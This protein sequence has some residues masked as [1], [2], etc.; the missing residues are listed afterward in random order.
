MSTINLMFGITEDLDKALEEIAKEQMVE[1][2]D[3]ARG[4]LAV[5]LA[6]AKHRPGFLGFDQGTVVNLVTRIAAAFADALVS[7]KKE[8][9]AEKGEE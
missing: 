6:K 8:K 7:T 4:I 3:I 1:K 2:E 5:H 9:P